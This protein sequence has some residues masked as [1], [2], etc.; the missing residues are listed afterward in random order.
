MGVARLVSG[1]DAYSN[2]LV[3]AKVASCNHIGTRYKPIVTM[4]EIFSQIPS[5]IATIMIQLEATKWYQKH[6]LTIASAHAQ[7][8]FVHWSARW[9]PECLHRAEMP[10]QGCDHARAHSCPGEM[11]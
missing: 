1:C 6:S 9:R 10:G 3:E 7:V 5:N 8:L 2:K 11:A 4:F